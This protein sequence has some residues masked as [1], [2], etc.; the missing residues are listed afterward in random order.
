[1]EM[2]YNY[3]NDRM[4]ELDPEYHA[5]NLPKSKE[6][7]LKRVKER[8]GNHVFPKE[9][10]EEH[11]KFLKGLNPDELVELEKKEEQVYLAKRRA[12]GNPLIIYDEVGQMP[13]MEELHKETKAIEERWMKLK[14]EE[15]E[16]ITNALKYCGGEPFP[17]DMLTN[18][19]DMPITTY[20]M[21][22]DNRRE[23]VSKPS[24]EKSKR[25]SF[26][27]VRAN[28]FA[29]SKTNNISSSLYVASI[30]PY[31]EEEIVPNFADDTDGVENYEVV[32]RPISR[33]GKYLAM[34]LLMCGGMLGFALILKAIL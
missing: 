32:N 17:L 23:T 3:L 30:D 19:N 18:T 13:N 7:Y 12:E 29:A 26:Y 24:G 16:G 28:Q 10:L 11:L 6:E 22:N 14:E 1:M 5:L 34:F 9:K 8:E 33:K 21:T 25:E 4:E 27:D 31:T 15:R 20:P 2:Y